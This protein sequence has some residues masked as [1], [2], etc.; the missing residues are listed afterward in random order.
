MTFSRSSVCDLV[1]DEPRLP[2][3]KLPSELAIACTFS[4]ILSLLIRL[5]LKLGG[6][7]WITSLRR[8]GNRGLSKERRAERGSISVRVGLNEA[9]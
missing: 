9:I 7:F 3:K 5:T 8:V 2:V 4:A 1:E 6:W